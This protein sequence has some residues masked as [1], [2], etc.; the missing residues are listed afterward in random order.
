MFLELIAAFA[1]AFAAAGLVLVLNLITGNRLPKW[2]MPVAAGAALL[3]YAIWSEYTWFGRVAGDLPQGVEVTFTNNAEAIWRPWTFAAPF[4]DRFVALDTA[5]IRTNA[6]V[7]HQ[8]I[9]DMYFYGRWSPRMGVEVVVDC[10]EGV[11]APLPSAEL[12][13]A[14]E[15]TRAAWTKPLPGDT[16]LENACA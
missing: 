11:V 3:G 4:V 14:G 1:A 15:A 2:A 12:D 9:A 13:A 8:R 10:R 6:S 5:S 7:P 16:T